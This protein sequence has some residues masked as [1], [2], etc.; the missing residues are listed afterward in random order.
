MIK[1]ALLLIALLL[2][3]FAFAL[4]SNIA[5]NVGSI[6]ITNN[7]VNER[8]KLLTNLVKESKY[9]S[10][11]LKNEALEQLI[12]EQAYNQ[13][14]VKYKI[15]LS[16]IEKENAIKVIGQ[17]FNSKNLTELANKYHLS[18]K[19][20]EDHLLSQTLW[21]KVIL[22]EISPDV[23]VSN[24]E[25]EKALNNPVFMQVTF[26]NLDA[27]NLN[28]KQIAA[29]KNDNKTCADFISLAKQYKASFDEY[30][31][32]PL[33]DLRGEFAHKL[34]ELNAR[35]VAEV[36]L[37]SDRQ[38]LALCDKS[39]KLNEA[40]KKQVAN[41]LRESKAALKAQQLLDKAKR[42]LYIKI[43]R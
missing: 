34:A 9:K 38:L 39:I 15:T 19:H 22:Y 28:D 5:A 10:L 16:P 13:I 32:M 36:T 23:K 8:V 24:S 26:V 17:K 33:T 43:Y 41:Q 37:G 6:V 4:E 1:Y 25:I 3:S 40:Q 35:E 30:K 27:S 20:L 14:A 42:E 18:S 29:L 21:Q 7:D 12:S 31:D 2:N 11:E